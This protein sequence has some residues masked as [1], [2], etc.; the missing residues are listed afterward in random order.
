[1]KKQRLD[2]VGKTFGLLTVIEFAYTNRHKQSMWRCKCECGNERI[3]SGSHLVS[4]RSKSCGCLKIKL[5]TERGTTHGMRHTRIYKIWT[6]MKSR[7]YNP[8]VSCFKDYGGRG[9]TVCDEW[10][11]SFES[12]YEWAIANGYN[13]NVKWSECT[14]DRIDVNGNYEPSN[15]RWATMKEQRKNQRKVAKL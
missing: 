4:G 12:F 15:C 10:K 9:I 14:I 3:V 2:I 11:N 1:M 6:G 13:P 8:S 7:C 5:R